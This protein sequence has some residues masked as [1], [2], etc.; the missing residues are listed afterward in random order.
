MG[1]RILNFS[2]FFFGLFF[3]LLP[4]LAT[5]ASAPRTTLSSKASY[6]Q[7]VISV[8]VQDV[9]EPLE[10]VGPFDVVIVLQMTR[11][12]CSARKLFLTD[13]TLEAPLGDTG[14]AQVVLALVSLEAFQTVN[15]VR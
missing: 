4:L 7:P 14:I 5:G 9:F 15:C 10:P 3:T 2:S 13:V 8:F 12:I 6:L 11:Q 1:W